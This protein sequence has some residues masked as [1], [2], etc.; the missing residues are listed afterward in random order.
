MICS[1]TGYASVIRELLVDSSAGI[2]GNTH[3]ASISVELRTTNSRFL[4]LNFRMPEEVRICELTLREIL[5]NRLSRGKIDIR[6]NVQRSEPVTMTKSLNRNA[7]LQLAALECS[8]LDVFPQASSL[9]VSEILRWPGVI[10]DSGLSASLLCDTVIAC[11]QQAL[12]E[13]INSRSREGG[14]LATMLLANISK[15]EVIVGSLT[16]LVPELV[17]RH[18]KKIIE[19]LQAAL[20]IA[21]LDG[22]PKIVSHEEIIERIRQEVT[23]Y[24]VRIDISEE[25]SRLGAHLAET[26]Y[27]IKNGGRVGKKLDF[28]M[29]ELN[30]EANTLGSKAVAKELADAS[31]MLKLLIEQMREQVQNLE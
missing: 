5:M 16:P 31:M 26:R 17:T 29:Q 21:V 4:D 10:A 2:S 27:M 3:T 30:R 9:H 20:G 13:L 7:L 8:V 1:M 22:S 18:Q 15:M 6:I 11:S 24:G 14:Q 28:M 19:R 25:L 23:I 12:N